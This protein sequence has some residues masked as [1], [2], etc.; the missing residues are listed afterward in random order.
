MAAVDVN[1]PF[2]VGALWLVA[3]PLLGSTILAKFAV[4]PFGA[5]GIAIGVFLTALAALWGVLRGRLILS[6]AI[7]TGFLFLFAFAGLVP[8]LRGEYYSLPSLIF[9][10][11]LHLPYVLQWGKEPA[12]GFTVTSAIF[13]RLCLFV[14]FCGIAQFGLQFLLGS[15]WAFP[16]ETF[17]PDVFQV[18]AFNKQGPLAYGYDIYRANG[19]F[20]LEPSFF[21]QFMAV[22]ILY[23]LVVSAIWWRAAVMAVALVLSYSGTGLIVL[24][25]CLPL[26]AFIH[27][28]WQLVPMVALGAVFVLLGADYL[29]LNL[30]VSRAGEFQSTGSSAFARFVG[31]VYLFDEFL[32]GEPWRAWFGYGAGAFK[33]YAW[34]V[35][36]PVAEMAVPKMVFEFGLLGGMLY[37]G[38]LAWVVFRAPV[39]FVIRLAV[40]V[41]YF[42]NGNY[43]VF[44]HGLALSLLV[45][46]HS[47]EQR[48]PPG[49]YDYG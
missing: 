21:S 37:F 39:P 34:Q 2:E 26:V 9:L 20:L 38:L 3:T 42:L 28:R 14:A 36:V 1:R 30:F 8:A 16:I 49:G 12:P 35:S 25:I 46:P 11:I 43:I 24:I 32:W 40:Y 22:G 41:T 44:S 31:G 15:A 23:E 47:S 18:Q 33:Q 5:M 45:W 48:N 10:V 29:N 4:P 19:I 6:S 27:R 13:S 7:L 17:L